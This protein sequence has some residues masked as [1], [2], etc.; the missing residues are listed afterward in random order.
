LTEV[1]ANLDGMTG[2]K[3]RMLGQEKLQT[4]VSGL[5]IPLVRPPWDM[6]T[7]GFGLVDKIGTGRD[8]L[9]SKRNST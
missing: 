1:I 9:P 8:P 3:T 6:R 5:R 4:G 2:R 7:D